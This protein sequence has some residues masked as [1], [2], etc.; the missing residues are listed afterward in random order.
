MKDAC[1]GGVSLSIGQV[2]IVDVQGV[3]V[4]D[5]RGNGSG[6]SNGGLLICARLIGPISLG[7]QYAS[8]LKMSAP[9]STAS[10]T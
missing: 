10:V 3:S 6:D 1:R 8:V 2:S 5:L 4:G 9:V 7:L